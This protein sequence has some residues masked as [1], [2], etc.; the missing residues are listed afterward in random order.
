MLQIQQRIVSP[1]D[2][3]A[4]DPAEDMPDASASPA[5]SA[6]PSRSDAGGTGD[7]R[8]RFDAM[9]G[10]APPLQTPH[11][12]K[13]GAAGAHVDAS[14][15]PAAPA[16][17]PAVYDIGRTTDVEIAQ[18]RKQGKAQLASTLENAK[19]A[20]GDFV[21]QHP[22]VRILVTTS[23]GNGGHPVLIACGAQSQ[24]DA[25]VHTHYHG[26]NATVGD[27]LGSK[28]GTNARIRATLLADPHT[29]FVLPEAANST[30]RPDSF[31]HDNYYQASWHDVKN[32]VQTT[33]DALTAAGVANATE[34]VVSFH[35]GGGMA[36]VNLM[37]RDPKGSLLK[38]DRIELYDCVYHFRSGD[39]K[40]PI[41]SE[42]YIRDFGKT[43]NGLAVKQVIYYRGTNDDVAAKMK[44]IA[45]GFPPKDGKARV[46]LVDMANEPAL[47]R[48]GQIDEGLDP[49]A[50]D[51]HGSAFE[52]R[53]KTGRGDMAH[54]YNTNAHYRTTGEFLG[55]RPR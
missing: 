40:N 12:R 47:V 46:T 3:G 18:L 35:S 2:A 32:E 53:D 28:A 31:A 30:A 54:N 17:P 41:V 19:V 48:N 8:A 37:Q 33:D 38:A 6:N 26:D 10:S 24:K 29:V 44:V 36:L 51:A 34:R 21:A 52:V 23:A 7:P 45:D 9:F 43:A 50:Q 15:A 1:P 14:K 5:P 20:Y 4:R 42:H 11:V 13:N 27:G 49:I 55:T 25:H 16:A 22:G 39:P